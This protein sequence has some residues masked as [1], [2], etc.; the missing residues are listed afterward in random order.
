MHPYIHARKFPDK[1]AYL[2]AG[3]GEIVTY[4]QL[5]RQSNRIAQLFRSLG[6]QAGLSARPAP[7]AC[8]APGHGPP[9]ASAILIP[10]Q[11]TGQSNV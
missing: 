8:G 6:L 10:L 7:R 2:M 4:G 1:P 9:R 11:G 5:D 3:S